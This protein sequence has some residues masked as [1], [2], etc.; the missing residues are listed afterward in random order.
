MQIAVPLTSSAH[1]VELNVHLDPNSRYALMSL[2]KEISNNH[3]IIPEVSVA[4]FKADYKGL[5]NK[6]YAILENGEVV[7]AHVSLSC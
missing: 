1:H 2:V 3:A 5:I 6:K 4:N 7:V